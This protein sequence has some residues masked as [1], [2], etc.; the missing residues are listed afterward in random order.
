M[1]RTSAPKV[2]VEERSE[3]NEASGVLGKGP[4]SVPDRQSPL[5][6]GAVGGSH[7][8]KSHPIHCSLPISTGVTLRIYPFPH[9][10][11]SVR[12]TV[13]DVDSKRIPE[14]RET[15]LF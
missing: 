10:P 11:S 12:T 5:G 6:Y 9:N 15:G 3:A 2:V 8:L 1:R 7:P 14:P 13:H 4:R